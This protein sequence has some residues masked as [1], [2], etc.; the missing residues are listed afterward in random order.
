MIHIATILL[1][2]RNYIKYNFANIDYHSLYRSLFCLCITIFS[3]YTIFLNW[4]Q[5]ILNPE[6][7]SLLSYILNIFMLFYML[8]DL[9]WIF[10]KRKF[11]L[12]LIIHHIFCLFIYYNYYSYMCVTYYIINECISA[13]NWVTI[14]FPNNNKLIKIINYYRLFSIIFIRFWI[15]LGGLYMFTNCFLYT[16]MCYSLIMFFSLDLY[17]TIL[18]IKNLNKKIELPQKYVKINKL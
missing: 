17:W 8:Y 1:F 2:I 13:F 12:D 7:T 6:C 16:T 14:I 18:I 3:S 15:W 9:I 4:D 5:F 10:I 11:R